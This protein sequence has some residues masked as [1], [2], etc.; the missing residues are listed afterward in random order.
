MAINLQKMS[1]EFKKSLCKTSGKRCRTP[2]L[3]Q[4]R[5]PT[6][7]LYSSLPKNEKTNQLNVSMED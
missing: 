3:K 1:M 5:N 2:S 7:D 6:I 4:K